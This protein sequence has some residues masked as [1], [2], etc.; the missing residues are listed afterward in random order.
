MNTFDRANEALRQDLGAYAYALRTIMSAIPQ[1]RELCD[2]V[3][4]ETRLAQALLAFASGPQTAE[5]SQM[6][7]HLSNLWPYRDRPY[8]RT[9]G[10]DEEITEAQRQREEAVRAVRMLARHAQ[11]AL[12]A[13]VSRCFNNIAKYLEEER[14]LLV[15]CHE[16]IQPHAANMEMTRKRL[17]LLVAAVDARMPAGPEQE[18]T[19]S[20]YTEAVG[21][22]RDWEGG[23]P[24]DERGVEVL[25]RC[26]QILEQAD[27]ALFEH[28]RPGQAPDS[29]V[30]GEAVLQS[31]DRTGS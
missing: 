15:E 5:L 11:D 7:F 31:F 9:V 26:L 27:Q 24:L 29:I 14:R 12:A 3:V 4:K 16:C 23:V 10:F 28:L 8:A 19:L 30:E 17:N 25:D 21:L 1:A 22:L 20:V 6:A 13:E 18:A 2:R